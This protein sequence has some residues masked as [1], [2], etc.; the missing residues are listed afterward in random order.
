MRKTIFWTILLALLLVC[1]TAF[2]WTCTNCGQNNSLNF[3]NL[4]GAAK[5]AA[6][7][8][9][10]GGCGYNAAGNVYC[11]NCGMYV[12]N[13]SVQPAG[14]AWPTVTLQM[15]Q[16][17]FHP[18]GDK[19]V[20]SYCGP[21]DY[22]GAGAYKTLK[23]R[24]TYALFTDGNY[25]YMDLD[26]MTVGHRRVYFRNSAYPKNANVP[27]FNYSAVPAT[28]TQSV[29]PLFGPGGDYDTFEEA[30]ISAGTQL[31]V[32]FEESGYVFCEFNCKLG[33]VRGWI[34]AGSVEAR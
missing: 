31:S 25:T 5:P 24:S 10:C 8:A 4:C 26:Y 32:F 28:L 12:G 14:K 29:T 2:A 7:T 15:T 30:K 6:S 22:H 16:V 3:C 20:Q 27:A 11:P 13:T 34:S 19:R 1:A 9:Y 18:S 21:G 17:Y 23:M 33:T